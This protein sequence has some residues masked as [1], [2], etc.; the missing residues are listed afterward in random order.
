MNKKIKME[1]LILNV[2][3]GTILLVD[4]DVFRFLYEQDIFSLTVQI[5]SN[6][7]YEYLAEIELGENEVIVDH[8]DLR[9]VA[10]NWIFNN[11]EIVKNADI[12]EGLAKITAQEVPVQEQYVAECKY[13][14]KANNLSLI[15]QI[16]T[17]PKYCMNCGQR[18]IY[19][20][21]HVL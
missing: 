3:T 19:Q 7:E 13:C 12:D 15:T 11:V 17:I 4:I 18:T 16:D 21:K 2:S 14:G 9:R 20:K 1:D 10:L 8:A 5:E 6:G